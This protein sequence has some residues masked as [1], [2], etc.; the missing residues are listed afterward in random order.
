M[1]LSV[2]KRKKIVK[3]YYECHSTIYVIRKM[4][5]LYPEDKGLTRKQISRTVKKF[6]KYGSVT[7][8][9]SSNNGRPRSSRSAENIAEVKQVIDETPQRSIRR[10]LSDVSNTSRV[11][12]VYRTLKYDLKV[13]PYTVPVLQHLKDTD[14][15]ERVKFSDWMLANSNVLGNI[16]FSDES[17]FS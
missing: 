4:W 8:Q 9:R 16:W 5:K 13:T 11:T 6:E 12:S 3:L 14:I 2:E 17:H 1:A 15:T 10:I 7:D